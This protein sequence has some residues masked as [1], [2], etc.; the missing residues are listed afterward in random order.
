MPYPPLVDYATEAEY[1]AH[2][3]RVYCSGPIM[4]FDGIAVRFRKNRFG[5]CFFESSQRD[6]T[7]DL[8]STTRS[9]RIDW[10]KAALQDP[11][12]ERF[13]GWDK[14]KKRYNRRRRVTI[15]MSNYVVVIQLTD[16]KKADFITAYLAD[17]QGRGGR[18]TS[19]EQIRRGPKWP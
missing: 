19:V 8:F 5:H 13:V 4:T 12:S 11:L 9:A 10:I 2:Y 15:V 7:K 14:V 16:N 17:T 3:E 1:R 18:F 6:R